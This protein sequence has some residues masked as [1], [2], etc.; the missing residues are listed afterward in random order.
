MK[1]EYYQRWHLQ[2]F[3]DEEFPQCKE[4]SREETVQKKKKK[5]QRGYSEI[6]QSELVTN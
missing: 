5:K 3:K 2:T 1:Q 4:R 6:V